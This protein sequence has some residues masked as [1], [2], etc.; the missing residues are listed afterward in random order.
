MA[1]YEFNS[2]QVAKLEADN[3]KLIE[4]QKQPA[5]PKKLSRPDVD[6]RNEAESVAM[7]L[8]E[9]H[10]ELAEQYFVN[11]FRSA[12][13][14]AL[15][16]GMAKVQ[17]GKT[18]ILNK[19]HR[20]TLPKDN[21]GQR[22]LF[23]DDNIRPENP[24]TIHKE[25]KP[26]EDKE[27]I[28]QAEN[29]YKENGVRS[30]AFKQ[31]FGDW[32]KGEGSKVVNEQGKPKEQVDLP[33]VVYHGTAD[34]NFKEFLKGKVGRQTTA[35]QG[36]K[37]GE[38]LLYGPGFYFT[39]DRNTAKSY[40]DQATTEWGYFLTQSKES[41][42]KFA[43]ENAKHALKHTHSKPEHISGKWQKEGREQ[44]VD[45]IAFLEQGGDI[46][47]FLNDPVLPSTPDKLDNSVQ[48]TLLVF[49]QMKLLHVVDSISERIEQTESGVKEVYLNIRNPFDVNEMQIPTEGIN[50]KQFP[51]LFRVLK[52]ME[53]QPEH[54]PPDDRSYRQFNWASRDVSSAQ[55]GDEYG[56]GIP[57]KKEMA[58]YLQSLGYDG[59]R[60]EA[61]TNADGSRANV[62]IAFEPEQIKD[63]NNRGTFDPKDPQ[64]KM[65]LQPGSRK[66]ENGREYVLNQ[67]SRW[68][69]ADKDQG[70]KRATTRD[71]VGANGELYQPGQF[72]STVDKPKKKR[73][74]RIAAAKER[75]QEV[76]PYTWEKPP[77]A[78]HTSIFRHYAGTALARSGDELVVYQ[79]FKAKN[80]ELDWD[81]IQLLADKYNQ[82]DRWFQTKQNLADQAADEAA[83]DSENA[84]QQ[85]AADVIKTDDGETSFRM[86]FTPRDFIPYK[87]KPG[88]KNSDYIGQPG[89]PSAG[90]VPDMEFLESRPGLNR[91]T[92]AGSRF[93]SEEAAQS[94][95]VAISDQ[96]VGERVNVRIDIP[97]FNQTGKYVVTMHEPGTR[98]MG[99]IG[100]TPAI[101]MKNIKL[102]NQELTAVKIMEGVNK[103]TVAAAEG[104]VVPFEMPS[105][106]ELN[107]EWIPVGYNPQHAVFYYDKRTGR[108]VRSG[109]ESISIGN[110]IFIKRPEYGDR[111][112]QNNPYDVRYASIR[113]DET[114]AATKDNIQKFLN[115][116]NDEKIKRVEKRETEAEHNLRLSLQ[117]GMTKSVNGKTYVLNQNHRWT[118]RSQGGLFG[119]NY[120]PGKWT[121]EEHEKL[122][123]EKKGKAPQAKE[124]QSEMFDRG[125]KDDLPGQS[126]LFEDDD[127]VAR[128]PSE[129]ERSLA[130]TKG[131]TAYHRNARKVVAKYFLETQGLTYDV[132]TKSM[133]PLNADQMTGI[134]DCVDMTKPVEVGPPPILPKE[135]KLVQWQAAGNS[136]GAFY[137]TTSVRPSEIG[138]DDVA[139]AWGVP[140]TPILKKDR[141]VYVFRLNQS[142]NYMKST[143]K[144]E[145]GAVQW[146]IPDAANPKTTVEEL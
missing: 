102:M 95:T 96:P 104:E 138:I 143:S 94:G 35:P 29:D 45:F 34:V 17:D 43:L 73:D 38:N 98:V 76:A 75:K 118:L 134:L 2:D 133:R 88:T 7:S 47:E 4:L 101:R 77:S 39:D 112:T 131:N 99:V 30:K 108:E 97:T 139:T 145:D 109:G 107:R 59:L 114:K 61:G 78:Y 15:Q 115:Q 20:W 90:F 36:K 67:N 14:M 1:G 125:K 6:L 80:P 113:G 51:R 141:K 54:Y 146:Y 31:W 106:E 120:K 66:T 121:P 21:L 46:E 144:T 124:R 111:D 19:N 117:P 60:H 71:Q 8:L 89:T 24:I 10:G 86:G 33:R 11:A 140:G 18:Y 57:I 28:L 13:V 142:S 69:R 122:T 48:P 64:L 137:S 12:Q 63:V 58:L 85:Y 127:A 26:V 55:Y 40:A 16:V 93:L 27:A 5:K 79:P 105:E 103:T 49:M 65:S 70:Q 132:K 100:Y 82:G 74:A 123:G 3:R 52:S 23:D 130:A 56:T 81:Q 92:K 136:R 62:W 50:R 116:L 53:S 87:P 126:L 37:D 83:T 44:L 128:K 9:A 32:E 119:D 129:S 84:R 42:T 22:R 135:Q 68:E 72:I 91:Q 25:K 41:A 110:T